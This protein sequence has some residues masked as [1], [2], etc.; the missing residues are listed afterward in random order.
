M[1]VIFRFDDFEGF[2]GRYKAHACTS[3]EDLFESTAPTWAPS[4]LFEARKESVR[5][6]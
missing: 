2:K 1:F 5:F 6:L 3:S 4:A